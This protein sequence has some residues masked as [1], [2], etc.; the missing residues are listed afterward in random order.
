MMSRRW[1]NAPALSIAC[2]WLAAIV[3]ACSRRPATATPDGTVREFIERMRLVEG[4]PTS[5]KAAFEL[6]SKRAQENLA[7]RAQRYGAASGKSI[8]PEAMIVPSRFALRFEPQ[9]YRSQVAG[10]H[11]LVEVEGSAPQERAQVPCM[12]EEGGWRVDLLLPSLPPVQLRPGTA[13]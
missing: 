7:A 6:L 5:S 8:A 10:V 11:A 3:P 12:Y 2:A 9:L 1:L 13:P 4:D